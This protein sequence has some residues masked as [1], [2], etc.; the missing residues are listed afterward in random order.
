MAFAHVGKA[1]GGFNWIGSGEEGIRYFYV[2]G[3]EIGIL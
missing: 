2:Y 3:F 1:F